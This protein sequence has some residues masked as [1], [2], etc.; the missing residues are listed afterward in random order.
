MR[1]LIKI[2]NLFIAVA[3]FTC[4]SLYK[5]KAIPMMEEAGSEAA[6]PNLTTG[7]KERDELAR[8]SDEEETAKGLTTKKPTGTPLL[9]KTEAAGWAIRDYYE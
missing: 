4:L 6:G 9:S 3:L 5:G 1:S 2:A 8:T 7:K